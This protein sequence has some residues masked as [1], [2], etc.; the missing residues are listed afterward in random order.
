LNEA[1]YRCKLYKNNIK[2][3]DTV[4]SFIPV[5]PVMLDLKYVANLSS[6]SDK[7]TYVRQWRAVLGISAH[8]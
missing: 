4:L 3:K 2:F 5:S 1:I 6:A 7:Y 8:I